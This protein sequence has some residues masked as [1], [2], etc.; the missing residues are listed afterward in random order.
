MHQRGEEEEEQLQ[1]LRPVERQELQDGEACL[2]PGLHPGVDF[3]NL[4][5]AHFV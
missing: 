1:E 5:R 4:L 3:I 2:L